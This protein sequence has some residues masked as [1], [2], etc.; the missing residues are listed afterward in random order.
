MSTAV[1]SPPTEN[2]AG[3]TTGKQIRVVEDN[4]QFATL[5][6]TARFEHLWRLANTFAASD[7][8]P[9]QF[10]GKP[11]NC[12]IA[13]QMAFR[14]GVDPMMLLQCCYIVHGKP[15]IEAKLAIALANHSGKFHGPIRY[16]LTGSGKTRACTAY[17]TDKAS[18][19]DVSQMVTMEMAEAEGWTKKDGSKWKTLPDLMLQYR[20]AMFLIRLNCPEVLMGMSSTEE[21][22]DSG[23][24]PPRDGN[25]R[26]KTLGELTSRLQGFQQAIA[27]QAEE[28]QDPTSETPAAQQ[29]TDFAAIR[30]G[31]AAKKTE[32]AVNL[33]LTAYL[34]DATV[35]GAS[36]E[37]VIRIEGLAEERREAIR[38]A[39]AASQPGATPADEPTGGAK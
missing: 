31:F 10:R 34:E 19:E 39:R 1:A 38:E 5:L 16:A 7:L 27:S 6:D 23:Q 11:A 2:G 14:L 35:R 3:H 17:A 26:P 24:P 18:G 4:G 22:E 8:V 25:A 37:D 21:L 13:L 30:A 12:F 15:G 9:Q 29:P 28:Q 20:A 33:L 36:E 32:T